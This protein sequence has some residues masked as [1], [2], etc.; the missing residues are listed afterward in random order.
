MRSLHTPSLLPLLCCGLVFTGRGGVADDSA[1]P[2]SGYVAARYEA[3][4]SKS[5]FSVASPEEGPE[6][7]DYSLVGIVQLDGVSYACLVVN[8]TNEHFVVAS[9]KPAKGFTLVSVNRGHDPSGTSAVLQKDGQSLTLKLQQTPIAGTPNQPGMPNI[10]NNF[11]GMNGLPPSPNMAPMP[12]NQQ[13]NQ[14]FNGNQPGMPPMPF[15]RRDRLIHIPPPPGQII[16]GQ[17][18]Q[19]QPA[20]SGQ[21]GQPGQPTSPQ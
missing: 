21:P 12:G 16:P 10:V 11:P 8:Q 14:A 18:P 5:P 17:P 19:S 1:L 3:L 15:R 20:Q 13:V 7:P 6:S 9:D 4:W 2:G